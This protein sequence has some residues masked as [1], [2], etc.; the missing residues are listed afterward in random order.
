SYTSGAKDG[1]A[2]Y[3]R[4]LSTY[5]A[6]RAAEVPPAPPPA[7]VPAPTPAP[8]PAPVPP[9]VPTDTTMHP[10]AFVPSPDVDINTELVPAWGTG[11]IP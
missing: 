5:K 6:I 2:A 7:P 11:A 1:T 10:I 9:P 8:V 4:V 3:K